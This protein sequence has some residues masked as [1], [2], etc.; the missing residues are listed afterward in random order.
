[1]QIFIKGIRSIFAWLDI[2]VYGAIEI[3]YNLL[4]K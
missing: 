3:I 1:M 2:I 4:W